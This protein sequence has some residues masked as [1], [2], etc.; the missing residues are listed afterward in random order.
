MD[1]AEFASPSGR[2]VIANATAIVYFTWSSVPSTFAEEPWRELTENVTPAFKFFLRVADIAPS[3]KI[4]FISSGGTVYGA[5]G[6]LPKSETDA[7]Y[8]IS[9]YGAGK[10]MAEEALRFVGRTRGARYAILRV[11]NALGRWQRSDRQGIAGITL[12]AARD[13]APVRLF[14]SGAQVRDFVDADDVAD[15]IY[16][17]SIDTEHPAATWNVGSGVGIAVRDLLE[18]ISRI[19]GR[20][21]LIENAPARSLDVPYIV[22]DCRKVAEDLGW[23]AKTPLERSIRRIWKSVCSSEKFPARRF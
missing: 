19:V 8:P 11:S 18:T 23:T 7:T 17:A 14:G 4:V 5:Q 22:L 12:R 1:A 15:A 16:A 3:A 21:I 20:P 13:G 6:D 10:L 2:D 9:S